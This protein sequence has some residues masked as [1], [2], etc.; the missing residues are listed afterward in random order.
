GMGLQR[1]LDQVEEAGP[2]SGSAESMHAD[3]S[4]VR[5]QYQA[6][7]ALLIAAAGGHSLLMR[8]PPGSGKT[9]LAQR[10]PGMLPQ[11]D[12]AEALEVAAIAAVS[13]S[14]SGAAHAH[15]GRSRS[16]TT[17]PFR[18]PHHTASAN[19]IVGGG[20]V[21]QPGEVSLA[22]R[23]VLFLDELPEFDRRVLESLR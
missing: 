8:G 5:G 4:D 7:R 22:H 3:L 16:C 6:K 18:A 19:A 15:P 2:V 9:M 12:A 11:P 14:V 17:P 13:Q 21:L 20:M 23:G 10:P 1:M